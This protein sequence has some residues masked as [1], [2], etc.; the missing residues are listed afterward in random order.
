MVTDIQR[1]EATGGFAIT[2]DL[3]QFE[4]RASELIVAGSFNHWAIE[5]MPHTTGIVY[6]PRHL[7][8]TT[9]ELPP[10]YYEYKYYNVTRAR[11]MEIDQ[12]PKLYH[13]PHHHFCDNVF[14][15]KNCILDLSTHPQA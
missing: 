6:T 7:K 3:G 15:T 1:N 4:G 9:I 5:A 8:Q 13:G 10:G 11:W 12:Q 2:F 14:G